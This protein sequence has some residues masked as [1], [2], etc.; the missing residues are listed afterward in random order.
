VPKERPEFPAD[1]LHAAV[2]GD[3]EARR[4]ID[5]LHRELGSQRPSPELIAEHVGELRKQPLL[6]ALISNW[7][8]DPRTQAFIDE[9][10]H[11]GL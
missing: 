3:A 5:A 6:T 2:P 8:D 9:L 7:F 4:R 10:T 11:T 1:E